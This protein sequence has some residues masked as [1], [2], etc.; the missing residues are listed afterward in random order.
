VR[1][2]LF[3]ARPSYWVEHEGVVYA[4]PSLAELVA[5]SGIAPRLDAEHVSLAVLGPGPHERSLI[6]GVRELLPGTELQIGPGGRAV[7]Q[8]RPGLSRAVE[9][10]PDAL[11][12][13]I[14]LGVSRAGGEAA[15]ALDGGIESTAL[16]ALASE[17]AK[18]RAYLA[19]DAALEPNEM[20]A[21]RAA[22]RRTG[23]ELRVIN[24]AEA[25]LPEAFEDAVLA[26][27][28]PLNDARAIA[29]HLFYIEV[30][31]A[32][33]KLVLS[34]AGADE[35]FLGNPLVAA[36]LPAALVAER[37]LGREVLRE[38]AAPAP[39]TASPPN[40]GATLEE[41]L[42]LARTAYVERV[43][44]G[45]TLP[46]EVRTA[47]RVGLEVLLPYL[48]DAVAAIGI[49]APLERLVRGDQGK[50]L[51]REALAPIVS[52]ALR[53]RPKRPQLPAPLGGTRFRQRWIE[54]YAAWLTP[55]RVE[56]LMVVDPVAVRRR[57]EEIARP[58][59]DPKRAARLERLLMRVASLVILRERLIPNVST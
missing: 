20:E 40:R 41:D 51:L 38:K 47:A 31:T 52:D 7:V 2:D 8:R 24:I 13:A 50:V 23:A 5:A 29:K 6:A 9:V 27:E 19:V 14:R 11:A 48:D 1:R 44:P 3:G 36:A 56:P 30:A 16:L 18:R 26:A 22:A 53:H 42:E 45:W 43:L 39:A 33:E 28:V 21:V 55:A 37:T 46:A 17:T 25:R 49:S 10:T 58:D 35:V 59:P 12:A 34:G 15:I 32:G 57:F 4:A 54:R